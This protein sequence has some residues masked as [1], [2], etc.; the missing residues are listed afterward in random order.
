MTNPRR[1]IEEP[2]DRGPGFLSR[3]KAAIA[4]LVSLAVL[5]GGGVGAY[6][7]ARQQL[8]GLFVAKDYPG[9]GEVAVTVTIPK[10]TSL[11]GIGELLVAADVVAS[12]EAFTRAASL[13]PEATKIQAGTF[14][15]KTR[16]PA[17]DAL[18]MLLDP[19]NLQRKTFTLREGK[20]LADHVKVMSKASGIPAKQFE[21]VLKD[22]GA[23]DLPSWATATAEGFIFPDTYEVP[24][25]PTAKNM[26]ALATTRFND[27]IDEIGFEKRAKALGVKPYDALIVASIIE[28]EVF[29]D[30]DRAKV[31]RVIYNRLDA[32]MR[33]QMDSTVAYAS[34]KTGTVWT[35]QAERD[36]DSPYNTYKHQ[37]L[38]IGPIA[39]PAKAALKAAVAPA[40]GD[41]LF[42][43][44]INLDTGETRFSTTLAEH[45]KA[46]A[47]LQ[48]WCKLSDANRKKC[49]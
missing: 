9:P 15:L 44:P 28:R 13:N 8:A 43:M 36:S 49:A 25:E 1:A 47:E 30:S 46:V 38:P 26:V 24:D 20:W 31:A 37:G 4:V 19:S 33:L 22:V 7:M 34:G 39:S 41:W 12:G 14:Q 11:T 5:V 45:N 29:R 10:G 32:G 18:A 40:Q 6:F 23:L 35:T 48:A 16:L 21:A 3:H 27:V 2:A 42:F 17:A